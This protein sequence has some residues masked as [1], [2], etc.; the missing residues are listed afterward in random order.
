MAGASLHSPPSYGVFFFWL[1][2]MCVVWRGLDSIKVLDSVSAP[3][4]LAIGLIL[5]YWV[6]SKAGGLGPVLRQPSKFPTTSAF[7]VFFVPS[8]TGMGGFWPTV[9]RTTPDSTRYAKS[10]RPQML[11]QSLG[12]PPAMTLF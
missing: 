12:L 5:L 8:P 4:M 11:G 2:K 6:T 3:F 1:L 9:A 10:K 7:L